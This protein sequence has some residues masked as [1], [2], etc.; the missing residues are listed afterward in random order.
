LIEIFNLR[1]NQ[2]QIYQN[3][4]PTRFLI[5]T[6]FENQFLLIAPENQSISFYIQL[7]VFI[8]TINIQC[9][10]SARF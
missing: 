4:L 6:L 7:V 8:S 1:F 10:N 3:Q 2:I 9:R 5:I